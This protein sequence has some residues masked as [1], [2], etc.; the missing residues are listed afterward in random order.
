MQRQEVP[1]TLEI[2]QA[3]KA[4]I[5]WKAQQESGQDRYQVMEHRNRFD[6]VQRLT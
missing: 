6:K 1:P 2:K 5:E 4:V 3:G